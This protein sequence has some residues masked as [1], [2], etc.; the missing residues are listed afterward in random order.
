MKRTHPFET[1]LYLFFRYSVVS[2]VHEAGGAKGLVN[3]LC[4]LVPAGGV[5]VVDVRSKV[6]DGDGCHVDL[7]SR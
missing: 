5:L 2:Q 3:L 6:H 4:G 7:L 1:L